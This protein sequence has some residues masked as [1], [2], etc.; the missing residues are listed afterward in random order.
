[1]GTRRITC[2]QNDAER[3]TMRR[4]RLLTELKPWLVIGC[5][6]CASCKS[7]KLQLV[8]SLELKL[9]TPQTAVWSLKLRCG[10]QCT[11]VAEAQEML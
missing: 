10:K 7:L 9:K 3:R 2:R 1:M 4:M 5:G 8:P 11:V 6:K